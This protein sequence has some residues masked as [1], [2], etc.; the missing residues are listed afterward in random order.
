MVLKFFLNLCSILIFISVNG[1]KA[2]EITANVNADKTA[3]MSNSIISMKIN[4]KGQVNFFSLNGKD[5]VN[6]NNKG[7]FYFSYNSA[8]Y[9]ELSPTEAKLTRLTDELA[10]ITH[11]NT[12]N[13]LIIEQSYIL[14]KDVP[15]AYCYITLKGNA[16]SVNLREMRVVYRV[17]P[18]MFDY[19]YVSDQRHGAMVSPADLTGVE[20]V[21]DATYLLLDGSIYTKYDWANYVDEDIVHGLC[22]D[23][24]GI[25]VISSSDEYLNGGPMKQELM[26]HGT[27]KT[28]LALKMLQGE[29]F[30]ASS[31]NY[32]TSDEK[33]YGPFFI[34]ANSGDG[35]QAIIDDAKVYAHQEQNKWPYTWMDHPL[36]PV[37]RTLVTGKLDVSLGISPE[38]MMVVL[39]DHGK[40]IYDQGKGYMFWSKADAEG[41]FTIENVR[42]DN[43]SLYVFATQGEMTDKIEFE[44]IEISGNETNLGEVDVVPT[45]YQNFIWQIGEP[46]RTSRGFKLSN[47]PRTYGLW[48]EVEANLTYTIG[49]SS[50]AENWYYAQTKKGHWD[51]NFNLDQTYTGDAYLTIGIAGAASK[52]KLAVYLNNSGLKSY[53]FGNDGSVYRSANQGGKYEKKVIKFE[54]SKLKA[55]ENTL[56]MRLTDVGNRG[57]LIYDVLK[58]EVGDQLTGINNLAENNKPLIKVYPNPVTAESTINVWVK[59]SEYAEILLFDSAGHKV[60]TI[61]SGHLNEGENTF[62]IQGF[63]FA[64]GIYL[65]QFKGK[66]SVYHQKVL[67]Y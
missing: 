44:N 51:I 65:I 66:N 33:I 38:N 24:Y 25:W 48:D 1:L 61:Y 5:L 4:S 28:P 23:E 59:E 45:K 43:Y 17:D 26:V 31:Q 50:L 27:S 6:A 46:D 34:Y 64:S 18:D 20:S 14:L 15:G 60:S 54:A 62:H 53:S 52:P 13:E 16:T 19:A 58:L 49:E 12:S 40:P 2:Q 8:D 9:H 39:A 3:E 47:R 32:T 41:N 63:D 35:K 57:G 42:P 30:G 29:H 22:N 7:R 56:S 67:K 37:E 55:G 11:T 36:Y 10:E 21:M